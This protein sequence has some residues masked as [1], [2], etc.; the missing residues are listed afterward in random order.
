VRTVLP[1][2]LAMLASVVAPCARAG[3]RRQ[4]YQVDFDAYHQLNEQIRLYLS[5]SVTDVESGGSNKGQGAAYLDITLKGRVRERLHMADW[6]R[7]RKFWLR[8][9]YAQYRLWDADIEDVSERRGVL[10]LT[11]RSGTW[12]HF[13]LTHR[14]GFDYRNL[15]GRYSQRYRYRLNLEY[16]A[17]FDQTPVIP[18]VRGEVYYDSRYSDWS[19][20]TYQTGFEINLNPHWRVEPYFALDIDTRPTKTYSDRVGLAVRFY[21]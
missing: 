20:Q 4:E 10:Q 5:A 8:V 9:G 11:I 12:E 14:L 16:E 15:E 19:K 2:V 7:E 13:Q 3:D 1:L 6:A 21:W 17:K 18:Y